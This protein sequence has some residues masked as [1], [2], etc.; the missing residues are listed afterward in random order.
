M[1]ING[2]FFRAILSFRQ[3]RN[4][5]RNTTTIEALDCRKHEN[6]KLI[7]L[8]VMKECKTLQLEKTT[9]ESVFY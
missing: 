3:R 8:S 1:K 5:T 7:I 2:V 9:L 6:K 4:H